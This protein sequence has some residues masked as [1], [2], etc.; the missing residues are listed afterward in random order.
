MT[1]EAVRR[2]AELEMQL[3]HQ[4]KMADEM[5]DVLASQGQELARL[6]KLVDALAS[7]YR[8]LQGDIA[9]LGGDDSPPPHY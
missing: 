1:D 8:T 2:I 6:T 4:Q 5:S 7:K 9:R 3:A